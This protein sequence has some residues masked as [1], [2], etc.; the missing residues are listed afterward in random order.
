MTEQEKTAIRIARQS[1]ME[2]SIEYFQLIDKKPT[3]EDL[4]L[5]S[6]I[7]HKY[8]INGWDTE[9]KDLIQKLDGH[10]TKKY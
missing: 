10:L 1:Q 3:L 5:T 8:I 6:H 7:L 2:R 9:M 4:V